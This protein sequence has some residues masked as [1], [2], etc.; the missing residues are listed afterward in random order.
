[1]IARRSVLLGAAALS[2]AVLAGPA[3]MA[4]LR[5]DITSGVVQPVP[6]AVSPFAG[7]SAAEQSL[8]AEIAQ[9]VTDDLQSSGL[10]DVIDRRAYI[11]SPEA[12]RQ[13]PSFAD[14]RQINAQALVAGTVARR[15]AA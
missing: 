9:V 14:W 11:Q 8:G 4:Q 7:S 13:T 12:L 3:A 15:R 10:F 1:M 5:V 2:A 6:I